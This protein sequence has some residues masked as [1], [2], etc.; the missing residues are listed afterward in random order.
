M[1]KV[2]IHSERK[3]FDDHYR[4]NEFKY[5]QEKFDGGI[6]GIQRKL[7]FERGNS[8]AAVMYNK[9]TEKLIFINQFRMPAYTR[10]EGWIIEIVAGSMAEGEESLTTMVREIEEET[11]YQ[12]TNPEFIT[13]FFSTPGACSEKVDLYYAEVTPDQKTQ[14]G[15]G[16]EEEGEDIEIIEL[17]LNEAQAKIKT[18][19]IID[20][21]TIIGVLWFKNKGF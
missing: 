10:G 11:G 2:V 17:T 5:S 15:G 1:K 16:L 21:K 19:E 3:I 13:S 6:S 8:V 18:G 20:A 9:V 7:V 12:V 4:I 14:K